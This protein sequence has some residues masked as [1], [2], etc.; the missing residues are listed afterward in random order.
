MAPKFIPDFDEQGVFNEYTLTLEMLLIGHAQQVYRTQRKDVRI[1]GAKMC[2][3]NKYLFI[4]TYK[5]YIVPDP[6]NSYIFIYIYIYRI[7]IY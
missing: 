4:Q 3:C 6:S 2:K 5:P 1:L 7:G